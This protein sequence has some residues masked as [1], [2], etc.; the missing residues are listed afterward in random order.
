MADIIFIGSHGFPSF[1]HHSFPLYQ[2]ALALGSFQA[3]P[4]IP[5]HLIEGRIHYDTADSTALLC[6][7]WGGA[8]ACD[9]LCAHHSC[10]RD[11]AQV[12]QMED[13]KVAALLSSA[14]W[15]AAVLGLVTQS[16]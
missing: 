1:S 7:A 2:I 4:Q 3:S 9:G 8:G 14:H 11:Y 6:Q 16:N 15:A 5:S 12:H 10:P 13:E